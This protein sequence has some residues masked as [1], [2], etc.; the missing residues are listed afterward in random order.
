[1]SRFRSRFVAVWLVAFWLLATQHCRLEAVGLLDSHAEA[2]P[3][4]CATGEVHCDHDGCEI[5]E[6][7]G[8]NLPATTKVSPPPLA[9]YPCVICASVALPEQEPLPRV[10]ADEFGRPPGWVT[11]WQFERRAAAPAH[12]PD[13]LIV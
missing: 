5:V 6:S 10:R 7:R 2:S 13:S 12:A 1:M 3:G 4:C 11:A 8:A 9:L